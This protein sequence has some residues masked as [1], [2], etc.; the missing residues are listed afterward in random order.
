MCKSKIHR[1]TVTEAN[2]NYV[3]SLTV[4]E[5]LLELS[6]IVPYEQVHVVNVNNGQRLITYAIPGERGSGIMCL[7]GAAARHGQP[8][9]I[10]IV[11]AYG[12]MEDA[13]VR[14][15]RPSVVLVD[16][17]NR[18]VPVPQSI[19]DAALENDRNGF[20]HGAFSDLEIE[21]LGVAS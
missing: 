11:I 2:L 1:A 4:D 7:N 21:A 5:D 17:R 19:E 12:H 18:P 15:F 16:E 20:H 10:V 3:G 14:R 9:D 6:N 13:E 8:G